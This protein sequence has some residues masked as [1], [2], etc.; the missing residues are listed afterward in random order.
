MGLNHIPLQKVKIDFVKNYNQY[1]LF[2]RKYEKKYK[3][4][5]KNDGFLLKN[6]LIII[7]IFTINSR[8]LF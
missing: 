4:F 5:M 3:N 8:F 7:L 6:I 2:F 1:L